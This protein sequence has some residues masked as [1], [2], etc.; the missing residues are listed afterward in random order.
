MENI[1]IYEYPPLRNPT[2]VAAFAGWPDAGEVA[3]YSNNFLK[4]KLGAKRFA[5]IM[6]EEFY[7]FTRLRPHIL[8]SEASVRQITWPSNEFFYCKSS[9]R[10][11]DLI[12]L[13]GIEPNLK[14]LAY[15][16]CIL[17]ICQEFGVER[18]IS[19]GGTLDNIPHTRE[20]QISGSASEPRLKKVLEQL[21]VQSSG[22][23]GPTSIH[24]VLID[25]CAKR[26]TP[27]ASLWGHVPHYLQTSPNPKV[28]CA[29]L[30][31]LTRLLGLEIDLEELITAGQA[32]DQ[33][34]DEILAR[35]P[36]LQRYVQQLEKASSMTEA[37]GEGIPNPE[38]I[39]QELEDF[40]RQQREEGG[41]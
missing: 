17:R 20:P 40:L 33:Q 38:A 35:N 41:G 26:G 13:V 21:S 9:G 1:R 37:A 10:A 12:T 2:L 25:A 29:L 36:D 8:I 31:K 6:P 11:P 32:L 3:T 28:A 39:V 30:S 19:L 16:D 22:Y 5:E 24:S 18:V 7:V 14:W 4:E 34:V 27:T 23:Q 15:V